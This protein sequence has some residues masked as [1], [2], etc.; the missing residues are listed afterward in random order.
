VYGVQ[1]FSEAA[2]YSSTQEFSNFIKGNSKDIP[3]TGRE[4]T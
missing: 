3:A 1:S 4:G 2:N